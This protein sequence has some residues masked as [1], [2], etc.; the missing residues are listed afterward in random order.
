MSL[1][2]SDS[3]YLRDRVLRHDVQVEANVT[4]IILPEWPVPPGYNRPSADLLIRLRPGYP[5]IPPDMWWFNPGLQLSSGGV[6]PAVDVQEAHLGRSWQRWSRHL[7][8][9][10]WRSGIDGI[11]SFVA[12]IRGELERWAPRK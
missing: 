11:E 9:S 2:E 12:L 3:E 4:C 6:I 7:D 1:P 8:K 5:D 10:Q